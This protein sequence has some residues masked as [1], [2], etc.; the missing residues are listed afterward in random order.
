MNANNKFSGVLES[1]LKLEYGTMTLKYA[2][3][4]NEVVRERG[5]NIFEDPDFKELEAE[6]A[7]LIAE[8]RAI[9]KAKFDAAKGDYSKYS[10]AEYKR[11][12]DEIKALE[13]LVY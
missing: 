4:R 11:A 3:E 2:K 6:V 1:A 13:G 12:G 9:R 10:T 8:R 5:V 7:R